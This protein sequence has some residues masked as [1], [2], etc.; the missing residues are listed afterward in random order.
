MSTLRK[1]YK[2]EFDEA[3]LL[4][5][6]THPQELTRDVGEK[7]GLT[8]RQ[9]REKIRYHTQ[10]SIMPWTS[11]EDRALMYFHARVG[12]KWALIATQLPN[13]NWSQVR[14]RF[15]VLEKRR[16]EG[17]DANISYIPDF[18]QRIERKYPQKAP[19]EVIAPSVKTTVKEIP[20]P[21]ILRPLDQREIFAQSPPD[22]LEDKFFREQWE[23]N[24]FQIDG[25]EQDPEWKFQFE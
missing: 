20:M 25:S 11:D 6:E 16:E 21:M 19:E 5:V 12:A 9:V 8:A 24:L 1:R 3:L 22:P 14:N 18:V 7:F 23:K 4:Y 13:R 15:V 10:G 2:R 17:T